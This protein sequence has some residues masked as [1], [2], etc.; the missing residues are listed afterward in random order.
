MSEAYIP[1]LSIVLTDK[2][3]IRLRDQIPWGL[4]RAVFSKLIDALL[5]AIEADPSSQLIAAAISKSTELKVDVIMKG[6]E[7]GG[8][9]S[10]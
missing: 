10:T 5:N 9:I 3:A 7:D 4:R 6:E 1:R 8:P 2:Q